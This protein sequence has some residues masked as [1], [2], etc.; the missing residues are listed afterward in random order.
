MAKQ[1]GSR[2][3]HL[4]VALRGGYAVLSLHKAPVNSL[5]LAMWQALDAALTALE[6]EPSIAGVIIVSGLQRDVFSAGNDLKELYPPTTTASRYAT[7]WTTSNRF[8]C[9]LARSRLA[10]VAAIR[11]AC[12]A[13]GCMMS[14]CCD[15]RLAVAG[16]TMGLNEVALG[17]PVPK[18]WGLMMARLI[19]AKAADKLLLTGKMVTTAEVGW[20]RLACCSLTPCIMPCMDESHCTHQPSSQ[21][22]QSWTRSSSFLRPRCL[23]W[24]T[25]WLTRVMRCC[26]LRS[27][28]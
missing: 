28:S 14:L 15:H 25:R 7:F 6:Q 5:D 10:T 17:I 4:S 27:A 11:G 3:Q 19:G 24:W 23:G 21:C 9:R 2:E 13:G 26:P 16:G 22:G 8:L 18:Y 20:R 12:P 1:G